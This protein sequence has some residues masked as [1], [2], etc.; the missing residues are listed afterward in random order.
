MAGR[1][2]APSHGTSTIPIRANDRDFFV[3][4]ILIVGEGLALYKKI[5]CKGGARSAKKYDVREGL[6]PSH[7]EA[8]KDQFFSFAV[9]EVNNNPR[10]PNQ[11]FP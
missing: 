9:S 6:A 10:N 7:V 8:V 4:K 3:E 1:T 2:I 11:Y 5:R